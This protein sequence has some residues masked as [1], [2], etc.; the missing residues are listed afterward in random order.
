M[1]RESQEQ[2][3]KNQYEDNFARGL[4]DPDFY[5]NPAEPVSVRVRKPVLIQDIRPADVIVREELT[6]QPF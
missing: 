3:A 4:G 6:K 1:S 5:G 2:N